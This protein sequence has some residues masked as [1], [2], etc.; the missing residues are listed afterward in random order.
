MDPLPSRHAR[1]TPLAPGVAVRCRP[2]FGRNHRRSP[3]FRASASGV[4]RPP[5]ADLAK[6]DS[7]PRGG[8]WIVCQ[9]EIPA[10]AL[11]EFTGLSRDPAGERESRTATCRSV[12]SDTDSLSPGQSSWEPVSV[13]VNCRWL[14][15]RSPDAFGARRRNRRG[16]IV[17]GMAACSALD[18]RRPNT[19]C[20]P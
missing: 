16:P 19:R 15:S 18:V 11:R 2:T 6:R 1:A 12:G 3:N 5:S 4:N 8:G 13:G 7:E 14:T 17:Q 10:W 20:L 9:W